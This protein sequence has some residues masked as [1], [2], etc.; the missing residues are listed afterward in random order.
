M[1]AWF[2]EISYS[3]LPNGACDDGR[4]TLYLEFSFSFL[5]ISHHVHTLQ[6]FVLTF[7]LSLISTRAHVYPT[8]GLNTPWTASFDDYVGFSSLIPILLRSHNGSAFALASIPKAMK[9]VTLSSFPSFTLTR[10]LLSP[11]A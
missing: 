8:T 7:F 2:E 6:P 5:I 11:A 9:I 10:I 3:G 4:F 1:S